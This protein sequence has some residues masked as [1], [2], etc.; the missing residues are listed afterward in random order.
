M[1]RRPRHPPSQLRRQLPRWPSSLTSGAQQPSVPGPALSRCALPFI[2]I[3]RLRTSLIQTTTTTLACVPARCKRRALPQHTGSRP[4]P[5]KL[6]KLLQAQQMGPQLQ[7][8]QQQ[9]APAVMDREQDEV[10]ASSAS[11]GDQ[12]PESADDIRITV[13]NASPL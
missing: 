9:Q 1:P 13:W 5:L 4:A 10:A 7:Q 12:G 11:A 6:A 8:A 2:W 3:R